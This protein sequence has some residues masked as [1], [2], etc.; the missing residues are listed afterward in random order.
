MSALAGT[1]TLLLQRHHLT[2]A[3]TAVGILGLLVRWLENLGHKTK[4]KVTSTGRNFVFNQFD[5]IG[6]GDCFQEK[7]Q[8]DCCQQI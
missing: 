1:Q 8:W 7:G 3:A 4:T 5:Q 2:G 6:K